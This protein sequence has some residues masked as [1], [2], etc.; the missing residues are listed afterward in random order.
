[1]KDIRKLLHFDLEIDNLEPHSVGKQVTEIVH[2]ILAKR[3]R[4]IIKN[5]H[6]LKLVKIMCAHPVY[7]S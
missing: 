3:P 4:K 5:V 7:D 1:V 6:D 2:L